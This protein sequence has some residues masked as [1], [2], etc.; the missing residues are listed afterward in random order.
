MAVTEGGCGPH[1]RRYGLTIPDRPGFASLHR[2]RRPE[3][4]LAPS[5]T[6]SPQPAAPPPAPARPP[7]LRR[8]SPRLPRARGRTRRPFGLGADDAVEAHVGRYADPF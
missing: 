8:S 1:I 7:E 2:G 4:A 6:R 5:R 3:G